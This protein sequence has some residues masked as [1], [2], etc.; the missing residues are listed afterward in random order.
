MISNFQASNKYM[1]ERLNN[2]TIQVYKPRGKSP[3]RLILMEVG[4]T[5]TPVCGC[6][7]Y[8]RCGHQIAAEEFAAAERKPATV[9]AHEQRM[10]LLAE[11]WA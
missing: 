11:G 7:V 5:R 2:Q 6:P 10:A 8:G 3:A 4:E 9:D 1:V